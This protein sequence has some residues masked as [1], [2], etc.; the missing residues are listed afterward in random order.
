MSIVTYAPISNAWFYLL[1]VG[2]IIALSTYTWQFRKIPGAKEQVYL[3][4]SKGAWLCFAVLVSNS[5]ELQ[6]KM[7]WYKL[8]DMASSLPPYFWF[9]FTMKISNQEKVLPSMLK[10]G[11]HG[12]FACLYGL[13]LSNPWHHLVWQQAWLDGSVLRIVFGHGERAIWSVILAVTVITVILNVRWI[14]ITNGMRRK[15]AWWFALVGF[16]SLGGVVLQRVGPIKWLSPL[17]LCFLLAGFFVTWGFYRWRVYN[18]F[19]LAEQTVVRNMIDGLLV[20][21][22]YDYIVEMN[23]VATTIC[24]GLPATVGGEFSQLAAAWPVLYEAGSKS[25]LLAM[26]AVREL[27]GENRYYRLQATPLSINNHLLGKTIVLEDIT[28]QKHSQAQL[29]EQQRAMAMAQE[30][31]SLARELHDDLYQVLGYLN[32]QS[33]SIMKFAADGKMDVAVSGLSRLATITQK[34]YDDVQEYIR[35][36]QAAKIAEKGLAE[37]LREYTKW[38]QETYDF[39]VELEVQADIDQLLLEPVAML[40]LMR[41]VQEALTNIRKHAKANHIRLVLTMDEAVVRISVADDGKGYHGAAI[42]G[43]GFGLTSMR[44]RAEKMGGKLEITSAMG[45]GTQVVVEV[46]LMA[47]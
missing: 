37:S 23:P 22:E 40:Q 34:A 12:S 29:I 33:Q 16:F 11:V 14:I 25:G 38:L 27:S 9:V 20:V 42:S 31:A 8:Q 26:E 39:K 2:A 24:K 43:E 35:G 41:I 47:G 32:V 21:D 45:Q 15:Q 6:D 17:P 1:V 46:P 4:L 28:E 18:I 10:Y 30:R 3:Q 13:M 19:T 44:E 5:N 7:F 36:V